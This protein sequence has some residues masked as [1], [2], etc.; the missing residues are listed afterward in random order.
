MAAGGSKGK[1]MKLDLAKKV[2]IIKFLE[3]GKK[4]VE[5]AY[6]MQLL[7]STVNNIWKKKEK[8]FQDFADFSPSSA[9]IRTPTS[10]KTETALV[11]WLDEQRA[12]NVPINGPLLKEKAK[13]FAQAFNELEFKGKIKMNQGSSLQ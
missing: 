4:Q 9:R 3:E 10:L 5:L 12:R 2:K 6:D 13:M 8:L 1:R 11:K 7:T